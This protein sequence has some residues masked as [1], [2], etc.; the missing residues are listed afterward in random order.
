ME[1]KN[2]NR[3]IGFATI[4]ITLPAILVG[5]G[6]SSDDAA[7]GTT[8]TG[9]FVDAPVAGLTYSC[10]PSSLSGTTAS[11]G[12]FSYQSGDSCSFSV[13]SVALGSATADAVVSPVDLVASG[14]VTNATVTNIVQTLMM[15]D[16]D[17]I[18]TNGINI[19]PTMASD[20]V[21]AAGTFDFGDGTF[22]TD[23]GNVAT[24]LS[25]TFPNDGTAQTHL[26]ASMRCAYSGAYSGIYSGGNAAGPGH[27]DNSGT[28]GLVIDPVTGM[29]IGAS[30]DTT[31]TALADIS[32]SAALSLD[33]SRAFAAGQAGLV[34]FSGS[35]D[36]F[37][38]VSGT[39]VGAGALNGFQGT[40]N[41]DRVSVSSIADP[42]FRFV[43]SFTG[44]GSGFF[45]MDVDGSNNV[46]GKAYNPAT[47]LLVGLTGTYDPGT[48]N[49]TLTA[50]D[51]T[52]APG[53]YNSGTGVF[54]GSWVSGGDN[55]TY[56]G[57]GCAM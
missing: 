10:A 57:H 52:T 22:D 39:W 28:W 33:Q 51:G 53:N 23:M 7:S 47:D 44:T 6:G 4:F 29:M 42:A 45:A 46:V 13:S 43:G 32:G 37:N 38:S 16:D 14:S 49:V 40:I 1:N 27:I 35:L 9:T 15:L 8:L 41:G 17:G 19:T 3:K 31:F 48:G 5:C 18:P 36:T 50:T 12:S 30:Y 11:G 55:G 24:A 34:S 56:S 26:T 54:S 2:M 25:Q 20:F 21:A